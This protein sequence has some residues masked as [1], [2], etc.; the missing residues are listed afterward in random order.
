MSLF[1]EARLPWSERWLRITP[2]H[3]KESIIESTS[4]ELW[5]LQREINSERSANFTV[6]VC[7][8]HNGP[9]MRKRPGT[10]G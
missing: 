6:K 9:T 4:A 8:G 7:H 10:R 5:E 3:A 2:E 1:H